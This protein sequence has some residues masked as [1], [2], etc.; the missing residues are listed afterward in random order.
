MTS[1]KM[2]QIGNS[3]GVVL[4]KE[5]LTRLNVTDGDTLY[6]TDSPDGSMKITSF[7]PTFEN[8]MKVAEEGIKN[9]AIRC[10]NSLNE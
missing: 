3:L 2:Q 7:D 8:Q 5:V 1:L 6:L 9:I 10:E 4:P